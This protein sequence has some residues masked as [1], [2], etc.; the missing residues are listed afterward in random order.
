MIVIN[1]T[2]FMFRL[3]AILNHITCGFLILLFECIQYGTLSMKHSTLLIAVNIK[4]TL[5]T[6]H[7]IKTD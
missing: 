4:S 1:F 6:N 2:V 7:L 3:D 5:L